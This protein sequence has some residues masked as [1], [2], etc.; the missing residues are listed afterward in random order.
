M[1]TRMLALVIVLCCVFSLTMAET[2][3]KPVQTVDTLYTA[4][5]GA[6]TLP[7]YAGEA[8]PSQHQSF[9]MSELF[10]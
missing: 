10:A 5:S 8:V 4:L 3:G 9:P 7:V 2:A 1:R 6:Y